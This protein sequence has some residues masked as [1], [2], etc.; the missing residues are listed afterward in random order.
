M[1]ASV[2][3]VCFIKDLETRLRTRLQSTA[4]DGNILHEVVG[5]FRELCGLGMWEN[6]LTTNTF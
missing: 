6:H 1:R 4:G 2:S 3:P 5:S